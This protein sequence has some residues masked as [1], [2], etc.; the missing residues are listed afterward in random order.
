MLALGGAP[1]PGIDGI[2]GG[3]FDGRPA[4][5]FSI[6]AGMPGALGGAPAMLGGEVADAAATSAAS[7]II[8]FM[9]NMSLGAAMT[10]MTIPSRL[11][12]QC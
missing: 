1:I 10:V 12:A 4:I 11:R 3:A 5:F 6:A 2:E 8:V 9:A 7:A